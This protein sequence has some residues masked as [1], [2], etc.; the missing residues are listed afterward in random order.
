MEARLRPGV[1]LHPLVR[2]AREEA[3][4]GADPRVGPDGAV[5]RLR[6]APRLDHDRRAGP[7]AVLHG[8]PAELALAALRP[9]QLRPPSRARQDARTAALHVLLRGLPL[10]AESLGALHRPQQELGD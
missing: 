6:P 9:I 3:P 8:D 10:L 1:D 2:V 7:D 4:V 5:P